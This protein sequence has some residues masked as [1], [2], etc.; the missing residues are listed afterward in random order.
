MRLRL[1][2]GGVQVGGQAVAQMPKV[3]GLIEPAANRQ[4]ESSV[5][6]RVFRVPGQQVPQMLHPD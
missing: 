3:R 6:I 1:H 2:H 5:G 4:P